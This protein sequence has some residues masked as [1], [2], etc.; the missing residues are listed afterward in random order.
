MLGHSRQRDGLSPIFTV[1][2]DGLGIAPRP[3]L[4]LQTRSVVVLVL[5]VN[6]TNLNPLNAGPQELQNARS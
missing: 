2:R 1:H 6:I 4:F 5:S 3:P